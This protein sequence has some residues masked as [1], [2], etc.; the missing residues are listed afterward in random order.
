MQDGKWHEL[1]PSIQVIADAVASQGAQ[2]EGNPSGDILWRIR[3]MFTLAKAK[4]RTSL[5]A[6]AAGLLS[7]S[8]SPSL[9]LS[10]SPSL[11]LP[12]SLS[13]CVCACA[14]ICVRTARTHACISYISCPCEFAQPV[15][16]LFQRI[17]LKC[18][19]SH[20]T[21]LCI[22]TDT[23]LIFARSTRAVLC[24]AVLCCAV[25]CCASI[26]WRARRKR[27]PPKLST[28]STRLSK[29]GYAHPLQQA[30][31]FAVLAELCA[32]MLVLDSP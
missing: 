29:T 7:L 6:C 32:W 18:Y 24:C 17:F 12:P 13:L 19:Q 25:L 23:K 3:L 22:F 26:S 11:S 4:V 21:G 20:E 14:R 15:P 8:L 28:K 2:E 10:L 1:L 27:R 5:R 16:L 30:F 9:S 31:C